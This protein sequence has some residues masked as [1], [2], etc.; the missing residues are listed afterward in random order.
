MIWIMPDLDTAFDPL[1]IFNEIFVVAFTRQK[2]TDYCILKI[3][4]LKF[5]QSS[6]EIMAEKF[7][8]ILSPIDISFKWRKLAL[9]SMHQLSS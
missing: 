7:P 8:K 5:H 2:G 9:V 3:I 4:N 6:K 1:L